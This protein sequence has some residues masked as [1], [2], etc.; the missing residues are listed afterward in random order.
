[1]SDYTVAIVGTGVIG[2]SLGLALKQ[3]GD[4]FR[5]LAHD[6]ELGQAKE[7][8]KMGAFDKAEWNLINASEPADLILLALPLSAIRPTLEAIAPYLKQDV[9]I[10]DTCNNKE[11]VL[12]WA[13]ELLPDHAHF[14]G[15]NPIVQP[16]GTGYKHAR[17]DLFQN[18]LYCLTPAPA[19]H[20]G[21]VQLMVGLVALLGAE[22]FFLD[23]GIL[24]PP[25]GRSAAADPIGANVVAGNP[26]AGRRSVR[27]SIFG[28][29]GRSGCA[30][31]KFSEQ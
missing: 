21:A 1:M 3:R 12:V 5:V 11:A 31:R 20:E 30:E 2:T 15:G 26:Q 16:G 17:A 25:A 10:S 29:R 28:G 23:C 27:K 9:V 7:A 24:A 13:N 14:V 18:R 8:V 22:P 6:K 4:E 19:A